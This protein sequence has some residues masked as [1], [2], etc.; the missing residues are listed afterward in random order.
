MSRANRTFACPIAGSLCAPVGG[1]TVLSCLLPSLPSPSSAASIPLLSPPTNPRAF[2]ACSPS[3]RFPMASF[4]TMAAAT[5]VAGLTFGAALQR[6]RVHEFVT[7][8]SQMTFQHFI[9]LKMFLAASTTSMLVARWRSMK[10]KKDLRARFTS[11]FVRG[12]PAVLLGGSL[13]GVGMALTGSCPGTVYAQLGAGSVNAR[14]IFAGCLVGSL[15]FAALDRVLSAIQGG[16]LTTNQVGRNRL[17]ISKQS[18]EHLFGMDRNQLA[19]YLASGML[20]FVFLLEVLVPWQSDLRGVVAEHATWSNAFPP[21]VSGVLIGLAQLPLQAF[22]ESYLGTTSSFTCVLANCMPQSIAD[23]SYVAT[24]V[25]PLHRPNDAMPHRR[26][27]RASF[28]PSQVRAACRPLARA[29]ATAPGVLHGCGGVSVRVRVGR[30]IPVGLEG[31]AVDP[32]PRWHSVGTLDMS[33]E[34]GAVC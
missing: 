24:N 18:L 14:Y 9:M 23:K 13:L 4:F 30:C 7:V 8:Q 3:L 32:V 21:V 1:L 15:A 2:L 5:A 33:P 6:G 17:G 25:A 19:L 22:A 28:S 10:G 12:W 31:R 16:D 26:S 27:T 29:L 11:S 20:G 34:H